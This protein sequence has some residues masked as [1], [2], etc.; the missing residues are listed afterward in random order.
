LQ[1]E[2]RGNVH[3]ACLTKHLELCASEHVDG[4]VHQV[5]RCPDCGAKYRV[6]FIERF[7]CD[8]SHVFRLRALGHLFDMFVIA[9]TLLMTGMA[10]WLLIRDVGEAEEAR[11]HPQSEVA[12]RYRLRHRG[13]PP[14]EAPSVGTLRWMEVIFA[15]TMVLVGFAVWKILTRFRRASSDLSI[16]K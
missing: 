5:A 12:Q 11:S 13:V 4:D 2:D 9:V 10:L 3:L 14:S 1:D 7:V 8:C 6:S 15:G 16:V